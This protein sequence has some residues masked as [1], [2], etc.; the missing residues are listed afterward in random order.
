M[1]MH[2]P[3]L[4]SEE[5]TQFGGETYTA[6]RNAEREPDGSWRWQVFDSAG[7]LVGFVQSHDCPHYASGVG[8]L[9]FTPGNDP[10]GSDAG[11]GDHHRCKAVGSYTWAL[12]LLRE[13]L[14]AELR[15][16]VAAARSLPPT[17]VRFDD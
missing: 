8:F 6:R 7:P 9:V 5:P 2:S 12:A 15:A 13:W 17:P 4:I 16:N 14:T 11:R 10:L 3:D 1:T